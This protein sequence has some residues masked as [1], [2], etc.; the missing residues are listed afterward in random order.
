MRETYYVKC[1][2]MRAR[3]RR[4][5]GWTRC[6]WGGL[7]LRGGVDAVD[8]T[9]AGPRSWMCRRWMFVATMAVMPIYVYPAIPLKNSLLNRYRKNGIEFNVTAPVTNHWLYRR[10]Q[11]G[12]RTIRPRRVKMSESRVWR[13]FATQSL[14]I[15]KWHP[16]KTVYCTEK[17]PEWK[18][19]NSILL[20]I[21]F[22]IT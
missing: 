14:E 4:P 9:M 18:Q 20:Y 3:A 13:I 7:R 22:N 5:C 16:L 11:K 10:S 19:K 17:H 15:Y 6:H 8:A 12:S 21:F 2:R 1:N